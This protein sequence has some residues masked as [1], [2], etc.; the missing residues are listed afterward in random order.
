MLITSLY[1]GYSFGQEQLS[2]DGEWLIVFDDQNIGRSESWIHP[3]VFD[4]QEDR[5]TI[6]V[7]SAWELIKQDYEGVAF[8]KHIFSVPDSWDDKVIRLQFGAVNYLSEIW[9]NNEVVGY[10]EGGF[11]PFEFR[12][13]E[14]IKTG[15]ENILMLR[16]MGP[17]IMTNKEID[18]YKKMET[19]QWRGGITGGI[20][21]SVKLVATGKSYIDD[22]YN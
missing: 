2:L 16:V 18:G 12:V 22:V 21:Q 4:Q 17:I 5:R 8:Y 7:P 9:L 11:T 19:A 13:D 15:E 1:A 14:M 6:S 3:E 20:Y 10:N